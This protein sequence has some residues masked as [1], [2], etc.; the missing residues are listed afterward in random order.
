MGGD[1]GVCSI[2]D[3]EWYETRGGL[4]GR[5]E[6]KTRKRAAKTEQDSV[7]SAGLSRDRQTASQWN[8]LLPAATAIN[9]E[10]AGP[11]LRSSVDR[12]K[13]RVG[14]RKKSIT[15]RS[16][17]CLLHVFSKGRGHA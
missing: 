7:R 4:V 16:A 11:C 13:G 2:L 10:A 14:R 15:R 1:G 5:G 8:V 3:L 12:R 17:V 9:L 6:V